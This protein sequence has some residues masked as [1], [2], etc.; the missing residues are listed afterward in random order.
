M[1]IFEKH[2]TG[3]L[4]LPREI[5]RYFSL[6]KE[7]WQFSV[8]V[9]FSSGRRSVWGEWGGFLAKPWHR[10]FGR[11][12]VKWSIVHM[13]LV[14]SQEW[15]RGNGVM[16]TS[17]KGENLVPQKRLYRAQNSQSNWYYLRLF[18]WNLSWLELMR[19]RECTT[20]FRLFLNLIMW[21]RRKAA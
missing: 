12:G 16:H 11:V 5:G 13:A 19:G 6:L 3:Y 14:L 1:N 18:C 17:L 8:L 10:A 9:A 2:L 4:N 21:H 15:G 7:T 20:K